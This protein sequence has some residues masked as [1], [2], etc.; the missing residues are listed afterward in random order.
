MHM[1]VEKKKIGNNAYNYLKVSVRANSRVISKT[2]A[3]LGKEPMSKAEIKARIAKIPESRIEKIKKEA[4]EKAEDINKEF[5]SKK[6]IKQLEEL[7]RDFSRKL[8]DLDKN[9]IEDMFR[10]FKTF[11]IYNTNSIEGNTLSLQETNLLLN[12]NKTP[13]G[14][15]LKDIYDH[16]NERETFDFMLE[17][18]PE[19]NRDLIIKTHSMLMK[20][21]DKRTGS[22]RQH[23]VRVFGAEFETSPAK[24]VETDMNLLLK[25]YK[26]SKKRLHPLVLAA[27]FHEKFERIHPF[28]D[29]NGRA[30]RMIAN[31]ILIRRGFPPLIIENNKRLK[32]YEALSEG[33]K[34]GLEGIETELYKPIVKFFY[35]E[36]VYTFKRIFSGWG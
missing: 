36:M 28:Y 35:N 7:K 29:G 32:Y 6:Q 12:E 22:F 16:I 23:N 27:L 1:H 26:K 3:Y 18:K 11:Y 4:K 9:L 25:W 14:K 31:L 30:G 10:D 13:P 19:I 20:N 15:D 5:L 33:H 24:F 17:N 21:I 34:A 2:V 8:R